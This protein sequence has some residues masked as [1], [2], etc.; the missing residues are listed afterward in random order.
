M[1]KKPQSIDWPQA[2]RALHRRMG[3]A[4]IEPSVLDCL[5]QATGRGVLV[6]CSG[7][8]DSVFML[9]TLYARAAELGLDLH[10]AHYN[11]R[12]RGPASDEDAAFVQALAACFDLS[13]HSA[14]RPDN[15]AAF[16][17]TT[18][19]ALRLEFLRGAARQ[20]SCQFIAFGHQLDDI[21][22]T[23][24]QRLSRGSGTE[25]LAAPRPVADFG[26]LPTHLR[27]LL[28]LRSVDIRMALNA[29]GIPWQEDRSNE[30]A[31]IARNALRHDVIP[32]LLEALDRDPAL[33]A[34]RSR[35][36][37]EEDATALDQLARERMPEA[38][39]GEDALDRRRLC[40]LPRA[41]LRRVLTAWLSAHG[42]IESFSAA[43]MDLLIMSLLRVD[44]P[45]RHSAGAYFICV[46][47]ER[48]W[49]E[50]DGIET[51]LQHAQFESGE[52]VVL[53]NGFLIES[54]EFELDEQTR[55]T[56]LQGRTDP[57]V[58]AVLVVPTE[59]P[60]D[61]RGWQPGD[62][63]RPL[64]APGSRKLKDWFIDRRIPKKERK[65]LP[66]VTTADGEVI[67]VPGFPPADRLKI[68]KGT[69]KALRLTYRPRNPR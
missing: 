8:A 1:P 53:S 39:A 17:E 35:L 23:Q 24:L 49:M 15:E 16:T 40:S 52:T 29:L 4:S 13:F 60:L 57:A 22:E 6:A 12:W 51:P 41:L 7:G 62:R 59:D 19:R 44:R 25:G 5:R 26:G 55:Q 28:N 30:D 66:V 43:A 64:G 58:E 42:L 20:A 47:R 56:V 18:A 2:A 3:E 10:L 48:V 9:C 65:Q 14:T 34:A 63:F 67:W 37:L 36:L 68:D 32:E 38:F 61:V 69:K 45:D 50:E 27:P 21:L 33:G 31:G 54:E 11:H 46:G